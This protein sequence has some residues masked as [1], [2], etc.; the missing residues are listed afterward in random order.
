MMLKQTIRR[1]Y[2]GGAVLSV[3]S[4]TGVAAGQGTLVA[5]GPTGWFG[6]TLSDEGILDERGTTFFEGYPVVSE[7]EPNS[8]AA[9][10]GVMPGDVLMSFNSRD[11]RGSVF[12][13]RNWLKPGAPFVLR[14]KR[15]DAVHIV[16]GTLGR[17]PE[18]WEKRVVIDVRPSQ[19]FE[20][21]TRTTARPP[22]RT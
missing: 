17:A 11:M 14:L 8:P 19:A 22:L 6:V 21:R 4:V 18:G 3:F 12:Q 10:A 20:L 5:D 9:K 7:V 13:L 16:R 1:W 15:N 2:L